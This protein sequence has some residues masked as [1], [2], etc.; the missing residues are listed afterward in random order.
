MLTVRRPPVPRY[1]LLAGLLSLTLLATASSPVAALELLE[2]SVEGNSV[3]PEAEIERAVYPHL[4]PNKTLADLEK[5][6]AALE[7]LYQDSGYLSVSVVVPEQSLAEGLARLQVVEGQVDRL[8]VSGNRYTSRGE[9]RGQVPELAPGSV[10]HFPTMQ[11]ELARAGASPDRRVTPLLRPG[12]R[13]G[14]MEVELAVED[15]LPLHGNIEI[16]NRQSPDTTNQRLEMGLRYDNLFQKQHSFGLNYVV[17]PKNRDEVSVVAAFY[18]APLGEGRSVSAFVQHSNSNIA[19]A[20]DS[21]VL[22][23]G[24]TIGLR[25]SLTLPN[26]PGIS[27][28]FHSLSVGMDYKNLQETQNALGADNKNT[29]LR[30]AP[31]VAQYTASHFGDA[32]EFTGNL[33]LVANPMPLSRDIDCQGLQLDQFACRRAGARASFAVARGD[34]GYSHRLLGWE[35]AAKFDFQAAAQPLVSPEQFLAGGMDTVRGY[36]EGEAS[37]DHGWRLRLE[38]KTPAFLELGDAGLRAVGFTES[39]ALRLNDP[40]AGQTSQFALAS[41]GLGLRLKGAKTGPLFSL[42]W[43]KALK[44]GPRT[45]HGHHRLHARLGYEF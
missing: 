23:K 35:M 14:T 15:S 34:L 30:Y 9:L 32:G 11:S 37:G 18:S 31:L 28:F 7:A 40:L 13:P 2:F 25:Y 39:A 20:A 3:L 29:P 22:G 19:T 21:T 6:R 1:P 27:G 5:A 24:T 43:A 38:A 36:L 17:A 45:L 10:P 26:P 33:S 41:A 4:G 42:D 44:D 12:R 8:K 16:N